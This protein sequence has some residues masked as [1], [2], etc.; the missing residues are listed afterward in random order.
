M[1][2]PWRSRARWWLTAGWLWLSWAQRAPTCRSPSD[3]DQDDLEAGRVA[4]V[5]EQDR[6]AAGLLE[7]LLGAAVRLRLGGDRLGRRRG[8]WHWSWLLAASD[9]SP[10]HE[11]FSMNHLPEPECTRPRASRIAGGRRQ[12]S[13]SRT[14]DG[15]G[16]TAPRP[17]RRVGRLDRRPGRR[18][19]PDRSPD[20]RLR[21]TR[22]HGSITILRERISTWVLIDI[23]NLFHRL[24]TVICKLH[25]ALI[26]HICSIKSDHRPA[27][28]GAWDLMPQ[29][30]AKLSVAA[31]R[32]RRSGTAVIARFTCVTSRRRAASE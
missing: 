28:S 5:L 21:G 24:S 4:H 29:G 25:L 3:E 20:A 6:G 12:R 16:R 26:R 22:S 31:N 10:L 14:A 9:R 32:R 27:W 13:Q 23:L 8:S 1:M 11:T 7:P 2:P 15:R 30:Y 17:R 18:I 19:S